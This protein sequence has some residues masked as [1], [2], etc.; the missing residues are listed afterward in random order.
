MVEEK[1]KLLE[2]WHKYGSQHIALL[3]WCHERFGPTQFYS[4]VND[5]MGHYQYI[6]S[7][8]HT[9]PAY[10]PS[11]LFA[12]VLLPG[13]HI[14]NAYVAYAHDCSESRYKT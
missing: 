2:E 3:H 6:H 7:T 14:S 8:S 13:R 10:R 9:Y 11:A 4:S 12:L 1:P 5:R